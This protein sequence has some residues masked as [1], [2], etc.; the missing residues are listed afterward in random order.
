MV[1]NLASPLMGPAVVVLAVTSFAPTAQVREAPYDSS[2]EVIRPDVIDRTHHAPASA[3]H[4]VVDDL[5]LDFVDD[6]LRRSPS[7]RQQWRVLVTS[8][9]LE[10]RLRLVFES[11]VAESHAATTFRRLPNGAVLADAAIPAGRRVPELLGHEVEHILEHLDGARVH[12]QHALG[13][14]S[15]RRRA[16][17]FETA[18]A[19][20]VGRQVMAEFRAR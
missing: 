19:A 4:I 1:L 2:L 20:L 7:F 14:A 17:S 3:T 9:R 11:P 16:G 10:V 13:D 5:L 18:R 8:P 12:A 6:L 15:I